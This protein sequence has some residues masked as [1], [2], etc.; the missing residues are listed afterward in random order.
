LDKV[1]IGKCSDLSEENARSDVE[2]LHLEFTGI[3]TRRAAVNHAASSNLTATHPPI[4]YP[5]AI[6]TASH[7]DAAAPFLGSLKSPAAGAIVK[8]QG[9][10]VVGQ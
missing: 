8:A 3:D 7:D 4:T 2:R 10:G 9:F 5:F 1:V 6:T